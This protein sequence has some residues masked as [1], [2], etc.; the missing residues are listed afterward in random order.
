MPNLLRTLLT[1]RSR[2]SQCTPLTD[3][4]RLAQYELRLGQHRAR[5]RLR[6]A[7]IQHVIDQHTAAR[8]QPRIQPRL[9]A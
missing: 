7:A 5:Q 6:A 4:E 3:A 9:P 1:G 8:V 2:W